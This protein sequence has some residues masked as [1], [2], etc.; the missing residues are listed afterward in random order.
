[1]VPLQDTRDCHPM[2]RQSRTVQEE[3]ALGIRNCLRLAIKIVIGALDNP[4]FT[5]ASAVDRGHGRI[6]AVLYT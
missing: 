5:Q 6:H 1:M 2:D 3:T 4:E